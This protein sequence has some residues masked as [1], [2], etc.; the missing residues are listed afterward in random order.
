[1]LFRG[2]S[3][4]ALVAIFW[5]FYNVVVA[6]LSGSVGPTT[7]TATKAAKKTCN[8]RNYGANASTNSDLGPALLAAFNACKTGGI[9]KPQATQAKIGITDAIQS[10]YLRATMA[11]QPGRHSMVELAGHFN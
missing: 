11:C 6:Q 1:M 5:F 10:M 2:S 7:S 9:G 4:A 8:V 3:S